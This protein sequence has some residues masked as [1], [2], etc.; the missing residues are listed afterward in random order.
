MAASRVLSTSL[1]SGSQPLVVRAEGVWLEL[2]DGRRVIDATNTAAPLGHAHPEI[3]AAV[4]AAATSPAINEGVRWAGRDAAAEALLET[5]LAGE[6]WAG[7]VRFFISAGEANDAALSLAQA[8]SGRSALATRER[9]YHGGVGLSRD[10]TVQPQWHG[11]LAYRDRTLAPPRLADVRELPAPVGARIAGPPADPEADRTG[12]AA[13]AGELADVAAVL[14]DY[15][16]GGI[17]HQPE[18]Q[19]QLAALARDAEAIWI[20]DETVTG[21][22]R[23]GSWFQFQAGESRPDVVIMGK[24]LAAGGAPAGAAVLSRELLERME[25]AG[26]QSYSSY[27]AHPIECAAIEAH[28]RVSARDGLWRRALDFD[29]LLA[30]EMQRLA[31]A[32]PG[33]SRID[34][35]G[36]H[37]TIELHGPSWRQWEGHDPDP[38][39]SQIAA[40]VLDAGAMIATSGEQTSLF[41]AP[42][43]I[44]EEG[45]LMRVLEGLDHGLALA[46]AEVQRVAG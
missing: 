3:V 27:R 29:E 11:G 46:D 18:Y 26:W 24:G 15:S 40:R 33:I 38:L 16:Q 8:L 12:L 41:I 1:T 42:P 5:A 4:R 13:V 39:A 2:E 43:L 31:D 32:H 36:L 20:A 9:A 25:D 14:I 28:V 10:L 45:E 19:D 35:R 21:L 44:V 37:W 30:R 22:G 34:G 23:V 7:A 6:D 17:Y